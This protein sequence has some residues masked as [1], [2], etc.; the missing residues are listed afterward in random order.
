WPHCRRSSAA[1]N[2][3]TAAPPKNP[4]RASAVSAAAS[5]SAYGSPPYASLSPEALG[6]SAAT[7]STSSSPVPT[8]SSS[9]TF[10]NFFTGRKDNVADHLGNPR[11]ELIRYDV[12]EPILLEVLG[13]VTMRGREQKKLLQWI[14]IV[15]LVPR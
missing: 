1:T 8:A 13:A 12:V 15:V 4:P 11:F 9:S 3:A 14:I 7:P 6:S 2:I 5:P 10:G